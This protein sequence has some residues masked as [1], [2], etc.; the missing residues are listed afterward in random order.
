[1]QILKDIISTI[2]EDAP[3]KEVR[4]GPFWTAVHS[5]RCGLASTIFE[6]EHSAGLPVRDA[7]GLTRK[8]ALELCE[9]A[10]SGSLLERS[11]GMAAINSLL[12]VDLS[13]CR[14]VNASE[15][16]LERGRNKRVCIVGHFPFIP[17][18]R[19]ETK[20]LWALE[21]RLQIGDL[22][23]EEA[24]R[25]IP[26]AD[27]LAITGTALTNGTM[28]ELLSFSRK[29][30]LVMVLG[31]T[32]PLSPVWFSYGVSLVS[33]TIVTDPPVV[34]RLASEGII[35][36]QFHGRGVQLVSMIND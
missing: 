25:V 12:D 35:F 27:L 5:R 9:Y 7:G 1:L 20:K 26:Q 23:E 4:V 28:D 33:G 6:H 8:S 10:L 13:L 36:R 29:D 18:L 16:L 3:V 30:A 19:K 2:K 21:R 15:V 11:I 24:A 34:L 32:T 31:P 22:P 14:E 17:R